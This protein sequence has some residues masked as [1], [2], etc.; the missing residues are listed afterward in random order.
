MT[1]AINANTRKVVKR[2]RKE[3]LNGDL[4]DV[5][6]ISANIYRASREKDR[7]RAIAGVSRLGVNL[8]RLI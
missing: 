6:T 8:F 4:K 7:D 3:R 5:D 1:A 2:A